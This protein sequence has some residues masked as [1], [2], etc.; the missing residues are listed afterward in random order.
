MIHFQQ[1]EF[2]S[3][4]DMLDAQSINKKHYLG[5]VSGSFS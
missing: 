5:P 2:H 3:I 4:S 1:N